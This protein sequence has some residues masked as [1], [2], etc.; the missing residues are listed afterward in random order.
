MNTTSVA[1]AVAFEPHTHTTIPPVIVRLK[2]IILQPHQEDDPVQNVPGL[3]FSLEN[4][5][6]C[7]Q[8]HF[9]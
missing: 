2:N 3:F 8:S 6:L 4:Q 5:G 9:G 1:P 7:A